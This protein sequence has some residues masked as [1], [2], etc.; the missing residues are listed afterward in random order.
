MARRS[1]TSPPEAGKKISPE[2]EQWLRTHSRADMRDLVNELST[3]G[4]DV[5][6]IAKA[7]E[8]LETVEVEEEEWE[9]THTTEDEE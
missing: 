6:D 1:K 2:T 4:E 8:D 9:R 7:I 5:T 3:M